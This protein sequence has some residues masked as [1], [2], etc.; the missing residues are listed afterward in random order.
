MPTVLRRDGFEFRIHTDDH[1]PSHV[2]VFKAEGEV[3]INL[4][5]ATTKPF[6]RENA[7]MSVKDERRALRLATEQQNYL[8]ERWRKIHG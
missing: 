8:L 1:E 7:R 2:H 3:V 6:V 4:G 5:D